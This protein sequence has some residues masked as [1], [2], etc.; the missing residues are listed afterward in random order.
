MTVHYRPSYRKVGTMT[1]V[2]AVALGL[3][4]GL[5]VGGLGGGGGVLVVPALVYLL[6]E[7][8]QEATTGSVVIVGVTAVAGVLTRLRGGV[9]GRTALAFGAV[10]VPSAYLGTHLNQR[11]APP[12]LLL[13]F[14]ALTLLAGAAMLVNTRGQESHPPDASPRR[15][16]LPAPPRH[17]GDAP[18]RGPVEGAS[19]RTS[20]L[21]AVPPAERLRTAAGVVACGLVVGFLTG[22]LGVGGGF[23]VVPALVVVLGVP[24][25]L[26]VGTSLA[27]IVLNSAS[28]LV[29]RL[30]LA[31]FDWTVIVP[32]TLAAVVASLAAKRLA[33]RLS[34]AALSRAFAVMLLAVGVFVAAQSVAAL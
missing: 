17:P 18:G 26:A 8:A 31:S 12:V 34:G 21:R 10:G 23:L 2:A 13:A 27:I 20:L 16:G 7:T 15:G 24:M 22:F 25:P 9:D 5:V 30:A 19:V 29:A 3:V 32:L 14:A 1:T 33:D 6:G 11:V 4:I 28:S